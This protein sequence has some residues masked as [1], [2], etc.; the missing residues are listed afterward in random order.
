MFW[1]FL[2]TYADVSNSR[3]FDPEGSHTQRFEMDSHGDIQLYDLL[4][5]YL[6]RSLDFKSF[7]FISSRVLL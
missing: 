6:L 1:F 3:R 5:T 2:F 4:Y 7:Y